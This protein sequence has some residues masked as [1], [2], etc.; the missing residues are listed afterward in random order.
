MANKRNIFCIGDSFV[1]LPEKKYKEWSE[2]LTDLCP[3]DIVFNLGWP[4]VGMED[5]LTTLKDCIAGVRVK[6]RFGKFS[7]DVVI[8]QVSDP[9][10]KNVYT[11]RFSKRLC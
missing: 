9:L 10:R 2:F 11:R 3:N 6:E 7:P 1:N 8:F 4:G 5:P